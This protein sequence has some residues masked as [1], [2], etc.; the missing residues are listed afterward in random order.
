MEEASSSPGKSLW[1]WMWLLE[2]LKVFREGIK[3]LS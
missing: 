3:E 1:R 2:L